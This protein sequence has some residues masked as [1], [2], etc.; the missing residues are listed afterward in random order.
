MRAPWAL[1]E[2]AA[3]SADT[4]LVVDLGSDAPVGEVERAVRAMG[5]RVVRC[6]HHGE[7]AR[8]ELGIDEL[9]RALQDDVR[10]A[11]LETAREAGFKYAAVDL[12]GYRQGSLNE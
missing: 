8:I 10:E 9:P 11:I 6:R 5:F 7:V 3:L 4:A 12:K 1:E 2:F